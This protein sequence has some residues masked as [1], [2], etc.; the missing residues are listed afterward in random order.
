MNERT[1]LTEDDADRV[2][3]IFRRHRPFVENVA[4]QHSPHPQD[5]PDIVQDVGLKVC[6][7]LNGFRGDAE[8]TTWLYR[9]TV[10]TARDYFRRETRQVIAVR[11]ALQATIQPDQEIIDPPQDQLVAFGE[12]RA[13]LM[14]AVRQLRP[15]QQRVIRNEITTGH[16]LSDARARSA[17]FRAIREL[18][19]ILVKDGPDGGDD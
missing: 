2:A 1:K 18:R 4:R 19:N 12:R 8:I 16:V 7:G 6:T 3:D 15:A 14:D 17:R 9:V 5:V 11:E 13:A 10:N